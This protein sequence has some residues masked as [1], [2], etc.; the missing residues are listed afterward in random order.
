MAKCSVGDYANACS[1]GGNI[2]A[3]G[4]G[5]SGAITGA[6]FGGVGAGPGLAA[7]S[8]GGYASGCCVGVVNKYQE[9]KQNNCTTNTSTPN[10][11][12]TYTG[13]GYNIVDGKKY[14]HNDAAGDRAAKDDYNRLQVDFR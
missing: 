1:Y 7:G 10:C 9:C 12:G 5:V 11:T 8:V 6:C 14:Y 2:G 4:G 3:I 13:D